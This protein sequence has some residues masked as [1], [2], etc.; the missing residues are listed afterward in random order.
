M[1]TFIFKKL[2]YPNTDCIDFEIHK[3]NYYSKDI[4]YSIG[5]KNSFTF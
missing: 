2:F 5:E 4:Y 1:K 3:D